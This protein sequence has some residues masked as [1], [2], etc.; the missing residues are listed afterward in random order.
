M[1]T[2]AC[3]QLQAGVFVFGEVIAKLALAAGRRMSPLVAELVP[4]LVALLEAPEDEE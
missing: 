3:A 4:K 2:A 1:I